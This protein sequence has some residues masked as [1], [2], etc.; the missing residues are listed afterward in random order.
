MHRRREVVP[1]GT[2]SVHRLQM[3]WESTLPYSNSQIVVEQ[4]TFRLW[5][6]RQSFS[7]LNRNRINE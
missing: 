7:V 3:K 2:K 4:N 6:N 5:L 1:N